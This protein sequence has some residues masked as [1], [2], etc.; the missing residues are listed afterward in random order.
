[1]NKSTILLENGE[2]NQNLPIN[3][4]FS[5]FPV[6]LIL[7]SFA[8]NLNTILFICLGIFYLKKNFFTSKFNLFIKSIFVF[9][10]LIFISTGLSLAKSIYFEGLETITVPGCHVCYTPLERFIKS[11]FF[12]RFFL[13]LFTAYLLGQ[14][15]F[16]R[17][18][19][20]FLTAA[21]C[22]VILS[23]DIIFQYIFNFDLLG[24]EASNFRWSGF[25]AD[26]NIAGGYLL[27]FGFFSIFFTYLFFKNKTYSQFFLTVFVICILSAGILFS[28]NKMPLILFIF[29]LLMLFLSHLKIKKIILVSLLILPLLFK[30]VVSSNES[31]KI[32]LI[33][34]YSSLIESVENTF[35]T[36]FGISIFGEG[37]IQKRIETQRIED[38]S[39]GQK[40]NFYVV[41]VKSNYLRLYL[42][43]FDTW[44]F[45][46][47]LGNGLKSFRE[48]CGNLEGNINLGESQYPDKINRL[49][50]TH[51]HNYYFEILTEMGLVGLVTILIIAYLFISSILKNWKFV[52]ESNEE[53]F[54]LF[55]ATI[56]LIFETLPLKTTGSLFTSNNAI[57]VVLIASILL[58][59]KKILKI[60]TQ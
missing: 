29:G 39:L 24:Y 22:S 16:L 3:I 31:Y 32:H 26:E 46:K 43:A 2:S 58:N 55:A 20:F 17:F 54:I 34:Q 1:M 12:F 40:T 7:G 21:F 5:L 36:P 52:K 45:N 42:T 35:F 19:Y 30:F 18:K 56:S 50:S 27:R 60:K 28:G 53:N 48:D 41:Q 11:L 10:F 14:Y 13:L 23:L 37:G 49:C 44:K 15:G 9:F 33:N 47:I 51:P 4:I 8:V 38:K 57:Y 59:Y 6:S 25:F